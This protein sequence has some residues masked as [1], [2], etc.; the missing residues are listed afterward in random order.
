MNQA[1]PFIIPKQVVWEAY[2]RVKQNKG[3]YGVDEVSLQDFEANLKDNLFKLWNRMS[4][5]SYFPVPVRAVEIPKKDGTK[6][7]LGIPTVTDRIAQMVVKMILEPKVEP[8]FHPDSYGY[9]PKK[10]AIEALGV[11]RQ[12]CW[13]SD[14]VLDLDIKGFFDSL[15]HELLMGIL[16]KHT[17]LKWVLLYIERWLKAPIQLKDGT[18]KDRK[19]GTPQ[20]GV[21]SPLLSNL[22]LHYAF[23]D[24][25]RR[26]YP[27]IRFE[28]YAD[29]IVVHCPR[30]TD[31]VALKSEIAKRLAEW[32]LELNLEKTKVVYCKD[33][34][35]Q[36][37]YPIEKFD[38]LGYTFRPRR[39]RNQKGE[40]FASFSPAV[41]AQAVKKMRL[42][43]KD[44][45]IQRCTRTTL[46]EIAEWINPTLRGWIGYYSKYCKSALYPPLKQLDR[47]LIKWAMRKHKKLKGH[48]RRATHWL[49]KIRE[50]EANLFAHWM[51]FNQSH[52][53]RTI[54]A[55]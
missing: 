6:R 17:D 55:V 2:K 22:Y 38:F 10:S 7:P 43:M 25:M 3:T 20:G 41:S 21:V 26:K 50:Q 12:R 23:D 36:G 29:D 33:S 42:V 47:I 8:H 35:R 39:S 48:K 1:K 49:W 53:P 18:L 54:R 9:R 44:W 51:L 19:K 16:Q 11:A 52:G 28:R 4:S 13:Q 40:Y 27:S 24:W 5:G 46:D 14:W 34:N 45:A 30:E 37:N 32:K 15:D 31:A